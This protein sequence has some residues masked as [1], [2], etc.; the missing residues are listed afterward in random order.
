MIKHEIYA[1]RQKCQ[2][3]NE[4][5]MLNTFEL[6]FKIYNGTE[7]RVTPKDLNILLSNMGNRAQKLSDDGLI[8]LAS[9]LSVQ[10]QDAGG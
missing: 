3:N 6:V 7:G 4:Q 9:V 10:K 1:C 8:N 5:A 2:L